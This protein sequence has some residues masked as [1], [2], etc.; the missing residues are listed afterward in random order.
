MNNKRGAELALNTIIYAALGIIVLI[1]LIL[2]FTGQFGQLSKKYTSIGEKAVSDAGTNNCETFFSGRRCLQGCPP[3]TEAN[4]LYACEQTGFSCCE[5]K[6][7]PSEPAK[8]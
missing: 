1:V 8:Q 3:G 6:Q 5:K 7:T 2:I 4:Q